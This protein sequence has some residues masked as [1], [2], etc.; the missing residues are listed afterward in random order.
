MAL[1]D[2]PG[3]TSISY[4]LLF[5]PWAHMLGLSILVRAPLSY[6]RE[7]TQRYKADFQI[8]SDSHTIHRQW[9]R[10]LCSGG[11]NH[12]KPLCVLVFIDHL[13]DKQNT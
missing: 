9:S 11:L 6:K 7:G 3:V 8:H 2:R 13:A 5:C 4:F 10:V 1:G 12:S